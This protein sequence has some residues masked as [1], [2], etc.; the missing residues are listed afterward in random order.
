MS[1][2]SQGVT[3]RASTLRLHPLD[4]VVIAKVPLAAGTVVETE[5]GPVRLDQPVGAGHKIAFRARA[6]GQPVHRYGQVIGVATVA[7]TPGQHVHT[8][9]LQRTELQQE[10][11]IGCDARPVVPYG[12]EAARTFQGFLRPDGRVGT[13]N[14]IAV[15]AALRTT[16]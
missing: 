7:I 8:H 14:Y 1:G 11:E 10:Y 9:N 15:V 5:A 6:P 16:T 12:P 13:R 2:E 3:P 4:D